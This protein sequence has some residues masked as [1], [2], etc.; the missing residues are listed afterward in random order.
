MATLWLE[1]RVPLTVTA[2]T[3]KGIV[4]R[5]AADIFFAVAFLMGCV[6]ARCSCSSGFLTAERAFLSPGQIAVYSNFFQ[7]VET[8]HVPCRGKYPHQMLDPVRSK[9]RT[10]R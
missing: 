2:L 9:Y 10:S 3:F 1:T 5:A 4:A 6:S 8:Q 7:R